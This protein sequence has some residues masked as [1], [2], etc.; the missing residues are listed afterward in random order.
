MHMQQQMQMQQQQQQPIQSVLGKP[1]GV[2]VASAPP[3]PVSESVSITVTKIPPNVDD[4]FI[5]RLL[6][7]RTH[8]T[9]THTTRLLCVC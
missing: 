5:K 1:A 3:K 4:E 2:P 6:E 9:G 8:Q 7:V